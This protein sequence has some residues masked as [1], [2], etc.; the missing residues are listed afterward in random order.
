MATRNDKKIT[1]G[2]GTRG[3]LMLMRTAMAY[4][5]I[6]GRDYVTPDDVKYLAPYVLGHR[7]AA[8]G[9]FGIRS[10]GKKMIEQI[11]SG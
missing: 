8:V 6:K 1:S 10:D 3:V 5:G 11:V 4:A 2:V 7:V 9:G